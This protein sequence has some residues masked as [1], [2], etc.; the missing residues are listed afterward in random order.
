MPKLAAAIKEITLIKSS[1]QSPKLFVLLI[2]LF[3]KNG[4]F[5]LKKLF[6]LA[7]LL[8]RVEFSAPKNVR[9]GLQWEDL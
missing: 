8:S 2:Q 7:T 4:N 6:V 5:F 3:S 9:V 1:S